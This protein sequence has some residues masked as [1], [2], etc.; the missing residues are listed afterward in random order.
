MVRKPNIPIGS[1]DSDEDMQPAAFKVLFEKNGADLVKITETP[2]R[3]I[4]PMVRM[5]LI[6][7]ATEARRTKS[8]ITIFCEALDARM[9]SRDRKGRLEA[10]QLMQQRNV[11]LDTEEVPL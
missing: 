5:A 4:L 3:M 8:L 10:V 2:T 11:D 9:I 7:S 6:N 1:Y